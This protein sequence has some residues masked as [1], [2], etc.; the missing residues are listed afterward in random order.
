MTYF[1]LPAAFVLILVFVLPT[2]GQ[3]VDEK[4]AFKRDVTFLLE[5]LASGDF[6]SLLKV[7]KPAMKRAQQSGYD[8]L[9]SSYSLHIGRAYRNMYAPD[10]ALLYLKLADSVASI[11]SFTEIQVSARLNIL[12]IFQL[13][14]IDVAEAQKWLDITTP[15]VAQLN[16]DKYKVDLENRLALQQ[17]NLGNPEKAA[18]HF[19]KQI[20]KLAEM[21]DYQREGVAL[22]NLGTLLNNIGRHADGIRYLEQAAVLLKRIN[23]ELYNPSAYYNIGNSF[24][25]LRNYDS[26]YHYFTLALE[27][28]KKYPDI[29][30]EVRSYLGIVEIFFEGKIGPDTTPDDIKILLDKA[31]HLARSNELLEQQALAEFLFGRYEM[32]AENYEQA[33][34]HLIKAIKIAKKINKKHQVMNCSKYLAEVY[35]HLNDYKKA[36]TYSVQALAYRDSTYQENIS[37]QA[38]EME[39]KYQNQKKQREIEKLNAEHQLAALATKN[40]RYLYI[41][42][43]IV[44]ILV[45][46]FAWVNYSYNNRQRLVKKDAELKQLQHRVYETRQIALQAQ[47]NPHFIFNCMAAA[48]SYILNNERI[49]ASELLIS[50]ADLVR[51]VLQNS[52]RE[53]ISLEE[54]LSSLEAY[55]KVEQLRSQHAFTY[56][57][58]ASEDIDFFIP[59]LL[60]QPYVENAILHGVGHFKRKEGRINVSVNALSNNNIEISIRDNGIGINRKKYG[61]TPREKNHQSLGT[62]I[63]AER[64]NLLRALHGIAVNVVAN[65]LSEQDEQGTN[66]VIHLNKV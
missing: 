35:K 34:H 41:G 58:T 31:V 49:Q 23:L 9:Y 24:I 38:T 1:H 19:L 57:I 54:E 29:G 25:Q 4:N 47:M 52:S 17:T 51:K 42:I 53:T 2:N 59:P 40:E 61:A 3:S 27:S 44:I 15:L 45:V 5:K 32:K 62:Q 55:L 8:S 37:Q 50:F 16:L 11:H 13:Q 20:Y 63:T 65:D 33:T 21:K 10:S 46:A 28:V 60:L 64:L 36:Y 43:S 66:V 18:E 12:V 30:M 22:I 39:T 56:S 48:D 6:E 14:R 26:A 7:A